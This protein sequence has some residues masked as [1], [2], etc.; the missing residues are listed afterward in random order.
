MKSDPLEK[1]VL[2]IV[3]PDEMNLEKHPF[4]NP[5]RIPLTIEKLKQFPGFTQMDD[6]TLDSALQSI[7]ELA[8]TLKEWMALQKIHSIDNQLF[9]YLISENATDDVLQVI[10]KEN[11][12]A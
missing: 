7:N 8:E 11:Q 10:D 4:Y 5:E 1:K 9:V 6:S 2:Q 3:Q 12:A